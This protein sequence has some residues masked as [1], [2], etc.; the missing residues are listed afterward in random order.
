MSEICEKCGLP[1]D[2]CACE[3]IAKEKQIITIRQV[4]RRFGKIITLVDGID[5]KSVDLKELTKQL[6]QKL[7]CGGTYKNGAIELQG[8]HSA[9]V[10]EELIKLGFSNDAV[11]VR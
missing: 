4:E 1:R 2:I 3:D 7:A 11:E 8:R 10:R 9:K 6:K 5:P